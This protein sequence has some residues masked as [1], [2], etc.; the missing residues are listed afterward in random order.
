MRHKCGFHG[1]EATMR[2]KR[3]EAVCCSLLNRITLRAPSRFAFFS[4]HA[5]CV[6]SFHILRLLPRLVFDTLLNIYWGSY[7]RI[8]SRLLLPLFPPFL[9]RISTLSI[10]KF[11]ADERGMKL[12]CLLNRR[13]HFEMIS[14]TSSETKASEAFISAFRSL[15]A[16]SDWGCLH[17]STALLI[18]QIFLPINFHAINRVGV[19]GGG[20]GKKH[21]ASNHLQT[22]K[23][24]V[25]RPCARLN[26]HQHRH[27]TFLLSQIPSSENMVIICEQWSCRKGFA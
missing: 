7:E 8:G 5:T 21:F 27:F 22:V 16:Y 15:F 24:F 10:G 4:S 14:F 19:G 26:L 25:S 11:C 9:C 13:R 17:N 6:A 12:Y 20:G 23:S 1:S 3:S 2:S 18:I